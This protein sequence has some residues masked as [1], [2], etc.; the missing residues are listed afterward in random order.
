MVPTFFRAGFDGH[1]AAFGFC[2]LRFDENNFQKYQ[3]RRRPS[4][5]GG[6]FGIGRRFDD[7]QRGG[8]F[9]RGA[10]RGRREQRGGKKIGNFF[11]QRK[12]QNQPDKFRRRRAGDGRRSQ[13]AVG[14]FRDAERIIRYRQERQSETDRFLE[15][16]QAGV[17]GIGVFKKQ[18]TKF[19]DDRRK[20]LRLHS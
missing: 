10:G 8:Y 6:E 19:Q 14:N 7:C 13:S 20:F 12:F 9:R 2:R 4:T 17:F 18:R 1:R 16:Q 5:A 3:R 15:D 11:G